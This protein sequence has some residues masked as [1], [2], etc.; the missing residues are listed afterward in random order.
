MK[1]I[2]GD[3]PASKNLVG[4]IEKNAELLSKSWLNDVQKHEDTPT[5]HTFDEKEL[6]IRAFRVY[7]HLGDWISRTKTKEDIARY[8]IALGD[9][10]RREGFGLSEVI[11]ALIMIRRHMW[12]KVISEGYLDT[13]LDFSQAI[14]LY[15]RVLVFFDRATYYTIVGYEKRG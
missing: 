6:Y 7:S 2:L 12:V 1:N 15:N 14:N 9:E 11:K 5:Y 3:F 8:Y 10:R 13:V 4:I